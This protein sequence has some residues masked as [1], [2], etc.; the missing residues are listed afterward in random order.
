MRTLDH[1]RGRSRDPT[2][3][4]E[5]NEAFFLRVGKPLPYRHVLIVIYAN[6]E[7]ELL[8]IHFIGHYPTPLLV[9]SYMKS[10]LLTPSTDMN[11]ARP[12]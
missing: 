3:V 10:V 8:Y 7:F 12:S 4:G 9:Y 11:I 6:S 5:G 2:S 1:E